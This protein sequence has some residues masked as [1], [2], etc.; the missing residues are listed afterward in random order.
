LV[1]GKS[2]I[3]AGKPTSLAT[4]LIVAVL[5]A[6]IGLILTLNLFI[7]NGPFYQILRGSGTWVCSGD[8][9]SIQAGSIPLYSEL[10]F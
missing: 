6:A 3:N 8:G 1:K 10:V 7:S 2:L 5:F 9:Q 4:Q